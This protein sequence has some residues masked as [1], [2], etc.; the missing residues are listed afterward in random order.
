MLRKRF[1][2]LLWKL[3]GGQLKDLRGFILTKYLLDFSKFFI[4]SGFLKKIWNKI[5]LEIIIC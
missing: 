2:N 5:I 3:E 1:E 4:I